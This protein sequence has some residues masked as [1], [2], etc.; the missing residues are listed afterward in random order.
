MYSNIN[1]K[2]HAI[3]ALCKNKHVLFEKFSPIF[4]VFAYMIK[5][6]IFA[7]QEDESFLLLIPKFHDAIFLCCADITALLSVR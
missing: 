5:S 6:S 7:N 2:D 1:I 3:Y 4:S